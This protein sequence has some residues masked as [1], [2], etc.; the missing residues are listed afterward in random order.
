MA[1]PGLRKVFKYS[2]EFKATAVALSQLEGVAV[3]DVASEL[4]IHPFMLS[5]WRKQV[6]EGKIVANQPKITDEKLSAELR[7]LRK[8]KKDYERLKEEHDIL[9]KSI[10]F[11]SERRQK[12]SSSSKRIGKCTAS[13]ACVGCTQSPARVTTRGANGHWLRASVTT[14]ACSR[15]S[16]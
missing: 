16:S 12:S 15:R 3:Q 2:E 6:R 7:E 8:M 5:L 10:R 4:D 13:A 11:I 14:S 9:K 1:K